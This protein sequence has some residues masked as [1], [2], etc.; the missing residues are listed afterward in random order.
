MPTPFAKKTHQLKSFISVSQFIQRL[1]LKV[2]FVSAT[3]LL[4]KSMITEISKLEGSYRDHIIHSPH[5]IDEKE[6][7]RSNVVVRGECGSF[8]Y[9]SD[10]P[11]SSPRLLDIIQPQT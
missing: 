1:Y 4:Q 5:F 2:G 8:N 7:Q 10:F 3:K 6:A 9:S 11:I